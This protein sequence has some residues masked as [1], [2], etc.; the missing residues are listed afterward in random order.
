MISNFPRL[1]VAIFNF[2]NKTLSWGETHENNHFKAL[3][4]GINH[5]YIQIQSNSNSNQLES[6][7]QQNP[8]IIS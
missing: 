8:T 1:G 7:L 2:E 5:K 6:S 3:E 4:F